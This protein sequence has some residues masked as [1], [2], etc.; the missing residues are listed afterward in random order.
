[1]KQ[2]S[3][4]L[5]LVGIKIISVEQYGAAPFG[6]MFLADLGAEVIKIENTGAR[7]EMGRHVVPYSKK[8]DSLFFQTFSANKRSMCLNLKTEKGKS[9]FQKLSLNADAILNNLRGDLP[10]KLG[11]DY[12]SIKNINP[13]IV[14][15]HLSAYGRNNSR[16][17]WP[18]L[19]YVMQA[20]AGYLSL[21]GEPDS[22]PTRFGL[23]VVDYQAGLTAAI[24]LLS[25]ILGAR[26]TG[27]GQD[28]DTALFDVAMS[29]LSYPAV[30]NLTKGYKPTRMP[31]SGH[32]SLVPSELYKT[33][34]GW[35][36][37]MA[38]KS[39]FWPKLV[40]AIGK[41]EWS[42]DPRIHDFKSRLKNRS[43]VISLLSEVFAKKTTEFWLDKL[44]GILPCAPVNDVDSALSSNFSKERNIVQEINH[45][46]WTNLKVVRQPILVDEKVLPRRPAPKLGA[47]TKDILIEN[48]FSEEEIQELSNSGDILIE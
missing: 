26:N 38:N 15:V 25:G 12:D 28:Y 33:K 18:G 37:I 42:N 9:V 30:W 11:L 48:N 7:G 3:P 45:P 4:R 17:F 16:E 8:N 40:S 43:L 23:S 34:D 5:P 35:I 31:R 44:T 22:T 41:P 32:P 1:M 24:A 27:K 14:C 21:T 36:F 29:N 20:E 19:D 13:K 47:D 6:S 39:S 2:H 10:T 46:D